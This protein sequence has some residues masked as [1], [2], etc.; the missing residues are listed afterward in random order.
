M[1]PGGLGHRGPCRRSCFPISRLSEPFRGALP[2]AMVRGI[3][4]LPTGGRDDRAD[5]RPRVLIEPEHV[6]VAVLLRTAPF[7]V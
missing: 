7:L 5:L 2:P 1:R 3:G 4:R 6:A